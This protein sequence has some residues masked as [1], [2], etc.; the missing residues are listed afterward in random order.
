MN[1]AQARARVW[2]LCLYAL[3]LSALTG[4]R[5]HSFCA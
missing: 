2:T 3:V 1:D 4:V 5:R